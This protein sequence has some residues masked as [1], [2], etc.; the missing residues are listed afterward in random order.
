M[1][2]P[3]LVAQNEDDKVDKVDMLVLV[4]SDGSETIVHKWLRNTN[5]NFEDGRAP[6]SLACMPGVGVFVKCYTGAV[7]FFGAQTP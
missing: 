6:V 7:L 2:G 4:G 1:R 5:G 3:L